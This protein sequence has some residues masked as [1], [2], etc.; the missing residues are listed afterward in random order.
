MNDTMMNEDDLYGDL[1]LAAA[2]PIP[3]KQTASSFDPNPASTLPSRPDISKLQEQIKRLEAEN[4]DL[5]KNMSILY[6]TA[7]SELERKDRRI[8]ELQNDLDARR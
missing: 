1:N 7:K 2:K 5:K 4:E 6:R 8:D 3:R